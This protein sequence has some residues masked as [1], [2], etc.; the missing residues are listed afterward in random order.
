MREKNGSKWIRREG[1]ADVE[2]KKTRRLRWADAKDNEEGKGTPQDEEEEVRGVDESREAKL[3]RNLRQ[4]EKKRR[5][6]EEAAEK[7]WMDGSDDEQEGQEETAEERE[8]RMVREEERL[9]KE[10]EERASRERR[11]SAET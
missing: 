5:A 10:S 2:K 6:H 1:E 8:V 11:G 3:E 7:D 4:L 9:R